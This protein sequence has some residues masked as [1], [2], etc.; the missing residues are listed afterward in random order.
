VR[1]LSRAVDGL[2][3]QI[4]L[5]PLTQALVHFAWAATH[6]GDWTAAAAAASESAR[7]ARD[8]RRPQH[9]LT[10]ELIAA[11]VAALRGD[12]P[13][14]RAMLADPVQTLV[15]TKSWPLLAT[16]HLARGAA[17]IGDGRHEDAFRHLWPVFDETDQAFHRYMR[18]SAL[19]DV[20][21]AAIGSGQADKL[22]DVLAELQQIATL[23]DVPFLQAELR[24]ARPLLA[25]DHDAERLFSDALRQDSTAYPFLHARTLFSFGRWLRRQRRGA[26]SRAPLRKSIELFDALGSAAWSRRAR[27]ELRA[28]GER[29]VR[30]TPD[31]RE[32]LTAQELQI[33]QF[34]AEGLSNR[35]IGERLFLSHRT[36]GGHLYRIFPKL[37]ITGRAQ[38]RDALT[39]VT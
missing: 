28:T 4:R 16:A 25:S 34:A 8:T 30:Q 10:V 26:D 32:R 11:L 1:F 9:G 13:A 17:A 12:E 33:A 7:L 5:G 14:M 18:W 21:E 39:R 24:Y 36:V 38:L 15:A 6:T 31:A 37:D 35:E 19:L 29:I 23:S 27:Q 20:V 3:E 22:T 2:R